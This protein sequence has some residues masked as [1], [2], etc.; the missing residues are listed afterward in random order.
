MSNDEDKPKRKR[1]STKKK[2]ASS[3]SSRAPKRS[4]KEAS[5]GSKRSTAKSSSRSKLEDEVLSNVQSSKPKK[6]ASSSRPKKSSSSSR[7]KP[8][9]TRKKRQVKKSTKKAP[10][11]VL[12]GAS[13]LFVGLILG[14]LFCGYCTFLAAEQDVE[15]WLAPSPQDQVRNNGSVWSA[16]MKVWVG[17]PISKEVLSSYLQASGYTLVSKIEQSFDFIEKKDALVIN[18]KG[19]P[20]PQTA[21]ELTIF[22][23]EQGIFS[24]EDRNGRK[25]SSAVLKPINLANFYQRNSSAKITI[26]LDKIPA[27]IPEAI[28]AMEDSRFYEH[29]GVDFIGLTRAV[30]VNLLLSSRAQGASTITQQLVKNLILNNSAKTYKRKAREALRALALEQQ[31][32]KT[33][34][35]ELYLN[36]V[37]LGQVNGRAVVGVGQAAK[38]YFGKS[39]ERLSVGEAAMLSGIISAPNAYSPLRHP[40]KAQERRDITLKRML[41]LGKI[42]PKTYGMYKGAELE[43]NIIPERRR[44][45]WFV[46]AAVESVEAQLGVGS[47]AEQAF[48]VQTT[49]SPVLQYSLEQVT[50]KTLADLIAKRPYLKDAQVAAVVLQ[51]NT[52]DVLAMVGGRDYQD[53]QFNRAIYAKRQVGSTSKPFLYGLLFEH[54]KELSPGCWVEDKE[55]SINIDGKIWTPQNYDHGYRGE[56]TLREA[57]RVSR[58]VPTVNI[59]QKLRTEQDNP[60]FFSEFGKKVGLYDIS[61]APSNALGAFNASPLEMAAAYSVFANQGRFVDS[62]FISTVKDQDQKNAYTPIKQSP[63]R[64]M[65]KET[66]WMVQS[67]LETVVKEGTAK[68]AKKYGATGALAGKTG[69][70]NDNNDAWFVGYDSAVI[71]AV[72]V[73]F[74]KGK[75]L[76]L[77]GSQ[78]ALPIWSLFMATSRAKRDSDFTSLNNLV[79][80]DVCLDFPECLEEGQDWFVRG[81]KPNDMCTLFEY[82]EESGIELPFFKR[83]EKGLLDQKEGEEK[84]EEKEEGFFERLFPRKKDKK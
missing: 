64:I 84:Q 79:K 5:G 28:L 3:S 14:V 27:H 74:D 18:N 42:D 78:A 4:K 35:L 38:I 83:G 65:S 70:T 53:S 39:V 57:L 63:K 24:I 43:L 47:I 30:V 11:V 36:E 8:K 45:N 31:L 21:T 73:G 41:D 81:S 7:S 68:S 54:D 72:W 69:T 34:L 60:E 76:G 49:L 20:K 13:S 9:K 1:R 52:G 48:E 29:E 33:E 32:S 6:G 51:A 23:S 22:F 15:K 12:R 40:E 25:R 59:Y 16:E 62:R 56:M 37:Y 17:A 77:T 75:S 82:E 67:M 55:M 46:D 44:A 61:N 58:N 2:S 26:R 10:S 66:A 50:K 80:L 71:V 19:A